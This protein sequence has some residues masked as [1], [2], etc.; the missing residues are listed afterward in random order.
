MAVASRQRHG[1][2]Y[3]A[4]KVERDV[5]IAAIDVCDEEW[6]QRAAAHAAQVVGPEA[7]GK[8]AGGWN[9]DLCCELSA[10]ADV[11][12]GPREMARHLVEWIVVAIAQAHGMPPFIARVLGRLIANWLFA[13]DD[14]DE[15]AERMRVLGVLLC[16]M[17]GD[18]DGCPCLAALGE[19]VAIDT[20]KERLRED[21]DVSPQQAPRAEPAEGAEPTAPRPEP[22]RFATRAR[23]VRAE[24]KGRRDGQES[25]EARGLAGRRSAA[26][27]REPSAA[28]PGGSVESP[29]GPPLMGYTGTE[30]GPWNGPH[31][32]TD[33]GNGEPP[34]EPP[35]D[36]PGPGPGGSRRPPPG[37]G[38]SP[39]GGSAPNDPDGPDPRVQAACD[40]VRAARYVPPPATFGMKSGIR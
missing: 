17:D 33:L 16:V 5:L 26:R 6:K 11:L 12:Q 36:G 24:G 38:S 29:T 35:D 4:T 3:E 25:P 39:P 27:P 30:P 23:R 7:L 32:G 37:P 21:L 15:T 19:D 10:V 8:L 22:A 20:L 14:L 34:E 40:R 9:T 13:P 2:R 1:V 31:N 18:L 28:E